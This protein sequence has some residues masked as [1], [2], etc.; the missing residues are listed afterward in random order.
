M[1]SAFSLPKVNNMGLYVKYL[2]SST[3]QCRL[4]IKNDRRAKGWSL[5][6]MSGVDHARSMAIGSKSFGV[7]VVLDDDELYASWC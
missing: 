3:V 5:H 7:Q 1:E 2:V 6:E 4:A